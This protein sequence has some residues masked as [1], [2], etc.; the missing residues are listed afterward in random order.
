MPEPIAE[1]RSLYDQINSLLRIQSPLINRIRQQLAEEF[2]E[3]AN[4]Q[5]IP[6]ERDGLQP[7]FAWLCN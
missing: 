4:K 7:L 2:P 3:G 5:Q 1:I 6:S